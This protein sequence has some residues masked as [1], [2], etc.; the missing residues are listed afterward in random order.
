MLIDDE[1]MIVD[2]LNVLLQADESGYLNLSHDSW[3]PNRRRQYLSEYMTN[4]GDC[5]WSSIPIS[6]SDILITESCNYR[7][8]AR[9]SCL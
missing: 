3:S 1:G 2:N 6:R 9:S 8:G 7:V 4:M 5:S